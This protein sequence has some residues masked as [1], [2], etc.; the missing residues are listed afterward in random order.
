MSDDDYKEKDV[1][2]IF[3]RG[4]NNK[5]L[6]NREIVNLPAK[7]DGRYIVSGDEFYK[8]FRNKIISTFSDLTG[9]FNLTYNDRD[10]DEISIKTRDAYASAV[11]ARK[12]EVTVRVISNQTS[13]PTTNQNA[14]P[15][16][17]ETILRQLQRSINRDFET[18]IQ[19]IR[20]L[21]GGSSKG[22]QRHRSH[23][24]TCW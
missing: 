10:G 20:A 16:D 4:M 19:G 24:K 5:G 9:E 8:Q 18:A 1:K 11:A 22:T 6:P 23:S 3:N 15:S 12:P 13:V 21:N 2:V 14:N 17:M 7:Y